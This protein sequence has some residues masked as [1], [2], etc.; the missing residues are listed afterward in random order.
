[1]YENAKV[2]FAPKTGNNANGPWAMIKV[3][4]DN[5]PKNEKGYRDATVWG[6]DNQVEFFT[7]LKPGDTVNLFEENGKFTIESI[8]G[9][10]TRAATST[11][12]PRT[13]APAP[14]NIAEL[15]A[16]WCEAYDTISNR[17]PALPPEEVTKAATTVFIKAS[18]R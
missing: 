2:K 6:H 8:E 3:N 4:H 11:S 9:G 15:C 16:L 1:M 14:V 10:T 12:A 13:A 5:L 17:L 18:G 7:S